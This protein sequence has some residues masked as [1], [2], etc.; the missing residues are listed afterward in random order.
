MRELFVGKVIDTTE[1]FLDNNQRI[2][3]KEILTEICLN[4]QIERIE[5]TKKQEILKNNTDILY[6]FIS[7]KESEGCSTI[8]LNYYKDNITKMLNTINLPIGEITT[9][10]LRNYLADYKSNSKAG[11]VTIDN[12]RRTLSSFFTW[13]ENEDY[14]VK[15]PVRRI[16][17]VKTT[18]KVKETLTDENLEKLRDTCSNVRDLA[19]LELLIST[20]MRVGEITR[21]N[22]SDMNFQERSCIVLGK[23]NSEREVYFS[24][25]SKMYIKKYLET[26]TDNNE[27]L[28]VSL[29]KPYNRLGISGIE[30][31]IRNLGKEANI[32]KVHPHKFRRTMATMAIDKGMP[33]EQVQKL[34]GHIKIDT[35]MEYAM[36]NQNNVKNS[37]RKYITWNLMEFYKIYH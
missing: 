24:A 8:T 22:I 12:I 15:S 18:R 32:N 30:I 33:I 5:P 29:I 23:G 20:G 3:L 28:F 21:L 1:D 11:M 16:H 2:K 14:I 35:T 10:I 34:L 7:S 19:I 25:K 6:K 37:H 9:E 36:V 4:Y 27:A 31:L 26:R 17:K 13:L